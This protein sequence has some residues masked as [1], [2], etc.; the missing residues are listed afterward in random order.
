MLRITR[1]HCHSR[2]G[3]TSIFTIFYHNIHIT[4]VLLAI[5]HSRIKTINLTSR[6][7]IFYIYTRFV[8]II[9]NPHTI[10][11]ATS[12]YAIINHYITT[13]YGQTTAIASYNYRII[14]LTNRRPKCRRTTVHRHR[15][16]AKISTVH[17]VRSII[18][19]R[20]TIVNYQNAITIHASIPCRMPIRV[21]IG[22]FNR[23]DTLH[24]FV[25]PTVLHRAIF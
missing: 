21:N 12:I 3:T 22:S 8:T 24:D 9:R 2:L 23:H 5:I 20:H 19:H 7:R 13:V 18:H 6:L 11:F 25:R 14:N 17:L 16:R 1:I 4:K 15:I 10:I